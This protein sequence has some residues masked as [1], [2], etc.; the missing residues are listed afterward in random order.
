M[1][2]ITNLINEKF[3][4]GVHKTNN[5]DDG[6][7]GSGKLLIQSIRKNGKHNFKKEILEFFDSENDMFLKE[8]KIVDLNFCMRPD[9][10]N[11]SVGGNGGTILTNRK[12]FNKFH[13]D[14]S[15]MK[16]SK[17]MTGKKH[18]LLTKEKMSK[19]H[20]SKRSPE[21]HK[22]HVIEAGRKGGLK[23]R[24]ISIKTSKDG[25]LSPSYGLKRERICCPFCNKSGAK[26]VMVR[27]HF[28][29]CKFYGVRDEN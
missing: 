4:I 12:P 6:Y 13:S 1:Y 28:D 9:T 18:G 15:K 5:I 22:K 7:M 20:F 29:K 3:Y 14:E 19:N 26:N 25:C 23:K 24:I 16:I 17:S 10:Y 21:E 27:F 8:S 2:K 11:I